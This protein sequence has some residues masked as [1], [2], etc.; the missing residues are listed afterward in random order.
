MCWY[1]LACRNAAC[2]PV[3][4]PQFLTWELKLDARWV[5]S[6][7]NSIGLVLEV[8]SPGLWQIPLGGRQGF[9]NVGPPLLWSWALSTCRQCKWLFLY[10]IT[11]VDSSP[12][13]KYMACWTGWMGGKWIGSMFHPPWTSGTSG[14]PGGW[15]CWSRYPSGSLSISNPLGL[16][17]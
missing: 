14:G 9:P 1:D 4:L 5:I 6:P 15:G 13:C 11:S 7:K 17:G 3:D 12:W 2:F 16:A 8:I 10:P